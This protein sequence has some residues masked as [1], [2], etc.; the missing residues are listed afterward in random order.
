MHCKLERTRTEQFNYAMDASCVNPT[1]ITANIYRIRFVHSFVPPPH[2]KTKSDMGKWELSS[3]DWHA[4]SS[5][6]ALKTSEDAKFYGISAPLAETFNN[7]GKDL[8]IQYQVKHE[9]SL[10]C[11][12][13]EKRLKRSNSKQSI[14]HTYIL[15]FL[16]LLASLAPLALLL[17]SLH[18]ASWRRIQIPHLYLRRRHP[19]LR[20]VR[21]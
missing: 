17:S 9:Q 2:R 14:L 18:Q 3:G 11:G 6:T 20:D 8:V 15:T 21:A 16:P 19:I 7:V 13:G 5:D 12:G 10:D 1:L 4:D